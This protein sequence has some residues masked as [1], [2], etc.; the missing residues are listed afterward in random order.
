M[1]MYGE[2][3]SDLE[4]TEE[5][6]GPPPAWFRPEHGITSPEQAMMQ[7]PYYL[8]GLG[9]RQSE[10]EVNPVEGLQDLKYKQ[11]MNKKIPVEANRY[12]DINPLSPL[13]RDKKA[14]FGYGGLGALNN[15]GLG[16]LGN[17]GDGS[18]ATNIVYLAISASNAYHGYKRNGN[19][20]GWGIGW[21][22][23]GFGPIGLIVSLVQGWG[24]PSDSVMLSELVGSTKKKKKKK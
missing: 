18:L 4:D 13:F 14:K 21:F 22:V 9:E 19:S 6:L 24:K 12:T 2:L 23:F 1:Y 17:F 16:A 7:Q 5:S 11:E 8:Y 10:I 20:V 3:P 15:G